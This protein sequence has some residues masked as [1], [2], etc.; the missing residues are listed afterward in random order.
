MYVFMFWGCG[1]GGGGRGE[2]GGA[3]FIEVKWTEKLLHWLTY[4]GYI[5]SI[6]KNIIT[7]D[8]KRN[9]IPHL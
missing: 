3:S 5:K 2:K 7:L 1:G 6:L 9:E 4:V 8:P